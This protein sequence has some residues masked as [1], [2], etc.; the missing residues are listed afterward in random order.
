MIDKI[1][2][3]PEE[4]TLADLAG[5]IETAHIVPDGS[6]RYLIHVGIVIFYDDDGNCLIHGDT[7]SDPT[8]LY[9]AAASLWSL[10]PA[11]ETVRFATLQ[12]SV[13]TVQSLPNVRAHTL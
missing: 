12:L 10:N 3:P 8:E 7:K 4:T 1:E 6:G 9:K 13:P 5:I 11:T 2:M